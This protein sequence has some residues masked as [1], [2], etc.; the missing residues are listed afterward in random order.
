MAFLFTADTML[1]FWT[2]FQTPEGG[3]AYGFVR[4]M[5]EIFHVTERDATL[6]WQSFDVAE[7]SYMTIIKNNVP[8]MRLKYKCTFCGKLLIGV[9]EKD[10]K[11]YFSRRHKDT[12]FGSSG[13]YCRGSYEEAVPINVAK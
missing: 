9:K 6:I 13:G 10:G 8:P 3:N 5:Q 7:G 11:H 1:K 12:S 2:L 4:K